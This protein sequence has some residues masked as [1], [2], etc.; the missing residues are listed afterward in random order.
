MTEAGGLLV[1]VKHV[2]IEKPH[3]SI[4]Q[5]E[6][7]EVQVCRQFNHPNVVKV[8]HVIQTPFALDLIFEYCECNLR[9]AWKRGLP[10][11]DG[12]SIIKQLC[13][14][15]AHVHDHQTIHRGLKP[16]NILVKLLSGHAYIVKIA[17]FGCSRPLA[18]A[19]KTYSEPADRALTKKVTTLWYRAPEVLLG[20]ARYGFAIDMWA[21]GCI[22]VEVLVAKIAFPGTS[23]FDM[24][25]RIFRVFGSPSKARWPSLNRLPACASMRFPQVEASTDVS[26]QLKDAERAFVQGMLIPCPSQRMAAKAALEHAYFKTVGA[27][28]GMP[29]TGGSDGMP[30]TGGSIARSPLGSRPRN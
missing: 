24:L 28:A 21:L 10:L 30:A 19:M 7:R 27:I 11:G 14:G 3:E 1:A 12:A 15:L 13:S 17:D 29:A 5:R 25:L 8:L 26:W 20:T 22:S 2:S 6:E 16:A 23:E 4:A 18:A 9:T